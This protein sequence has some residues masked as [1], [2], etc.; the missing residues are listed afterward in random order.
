MR[1]RHAFWIAVL[2]LAGVA[3]PLNAQR[4]PKPAEPGGASQLEAPH[5]DWL[6]E[7]VKYLI[8]PE[9]CRAFFRLATDEERDRFIESFWARRDP[10]PDTR[11]NEFKDEHYRRIAY[12]N[13]LF[14]SSRPG[15]RTD[16]GRSYILLG[17]PYEIESHPSGGEYRPPGQDGGF[18][19]AHPF[20][21]WRYRG[22]GGAV[23]DTML[24]FIDS[25]ED[26]EYPLRT[27]PAGE[28]AP[29]DR[30]GCL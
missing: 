9:E 24:E 15:W 8:A 6:Q 18:T 7:D 10:T 17:P 21:V 29:T 13:D 30:V 22:T 16:R 28:S 1:N 19:S 11:R 23:G 27:D 25:A 5:R 26:G 12:S 20:E 4:R 14:R 2:V 3:I